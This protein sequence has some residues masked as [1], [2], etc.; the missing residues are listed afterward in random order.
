MEMLWKMTFR[1]P[2]EK[3]DDVISLTTYFILSQLPT[4][5]LL[6]PLSSLSLALCRE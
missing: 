2:P 1:P 3:P 4:V 6:P 5:R